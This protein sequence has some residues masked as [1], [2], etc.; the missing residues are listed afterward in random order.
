MLRLSLTD[1][2]TV[3]MKRCDSSRGNICCCIEGSDAMYAA[4]G[5]RWNCPGGYWLRCLASLELHRSEANLD[6][7]NDDK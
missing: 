4:H 2:H 3:E 1:S 6:S 5:R 7:S